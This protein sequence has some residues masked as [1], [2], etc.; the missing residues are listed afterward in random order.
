LK[1]GGQT[2]AVTNVESWKEGRSGRQKCKIT[3]EGIMK[4]GGG[5]LYDYRLRVHPTHLFDDVQQKRKEILEKER[6]YFTRH[7]LSDSRIERLESSENKQGRLKEGSIGI[8]MLQKELSFKKSA[9]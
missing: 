2:T 6:L 4:R 9:S 3:G 8:G 1:D 5:N 7:A